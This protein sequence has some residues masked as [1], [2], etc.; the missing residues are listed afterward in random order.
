MA[1]LQILHLPSLVDGEEITPRFALVIDQADGDQVPDS[2]RLFAERIG[3]ADVV[4]VPTTMTVGTGDDS[5]EDDDGSTA[6]VGLVWSKDQPDVTA[7]FVDAAHE[8]LAR[9]GSPAAP[10]EQP[11]VAEQR[12]AKVWGATPGKDPRD[13]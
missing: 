9:F 2:L 7:A 8:V 5:D 4:A 11:P 13:G 10:A 3:A 1:R 12:A 6:M